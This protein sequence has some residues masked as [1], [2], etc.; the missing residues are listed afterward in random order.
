MRCGPCTTEGCKSPV[1]NPAK[2]ASPKTEGL[3]G[4]LSDWHQLP[5]PQ[6]GNSRTRLG[7]LVKQIRAHSTAAKKSPAAQVPDCTTLAGTSTTS[8]SAGGMMPRSRRFARHSQQAK[9]SSR[10]HHGEYICRVSTSAGE[11]ACVCTPAH[12]QV[13][14]CGVLALWKDTKRHYKQPKPV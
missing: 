7:G 10:W 8:S 5:P 2:S 4:A 1:R 14:E 6:V 3:G 11:C 12:T 13:R 9:T